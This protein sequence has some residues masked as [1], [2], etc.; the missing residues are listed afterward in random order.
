MINRH[1]KGKMPELT[2]DDFKRMKKYDRQQYDQFCRKLY[3][4]GWEDGYDAGYSGAQ[5][6]T[7]EEV[8]EVLSKTKGIGP[9]KLAEIQKNIEE[10]L[11]IKE[12]PLYGGG[13]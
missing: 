9:V 11:K 3:E 5:G 10:A 13:A 4:L 6:L 1:V 2:R 12:I 8:F 7:G